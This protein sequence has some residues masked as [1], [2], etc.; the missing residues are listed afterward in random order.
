MLTEQRP[1]T[2][3]ITKRYRSDINDD[4]HHRPIR[5]S[6]YRRIQARRGD[7]VKFSSQPDPAVIMTT[8]DRNTQA[9]RGGRTA[10]VASPMK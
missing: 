8:T 5:R 2:S 10:V 3:T 1:Q 4:G 7:E 9:K 6:T